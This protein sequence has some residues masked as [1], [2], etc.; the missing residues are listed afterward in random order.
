MLRFD[1]SELVASLSSI[2]K[3][4]RIAFEST[5]SSPANNNFMKPIYEYFYKNAYQWNQLIRSIRVNST[6]EYDPIFVPQ[7]FSWDC[8]LACCS[9]VLKWVSLLFLLLYYLILLI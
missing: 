1:P 8:G 9:M 3:S 5:I 2:E 4:L 6:N 7:Y